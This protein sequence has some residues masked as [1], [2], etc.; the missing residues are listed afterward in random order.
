MQQP[1]RP[2]GRVSVKGVVFQRGRVLL[3]RNE[4]QEWELPGGGL[5]LGETPEECV[6]REIREETG[7]SVR[8]GRLLDTWIYHVS[9]SDGEVLIVTYACGLLDPEAVPVLSDEHAEV[10]LFGPDEID[11][12]PLPDGY[13]ASI[14]AATA[15]SSVDVGN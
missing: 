15:G 9:P 7:W 8:C 1:E 11:D 5:E 4:R 12:L 6:V 2:R 3:L 10:G 14:R 13:R